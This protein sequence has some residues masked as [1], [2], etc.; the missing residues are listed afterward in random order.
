[1]MALESKGLYFRLGTVIL[2]IFYC[3]M[4]LCAY[5]LFEKCSLTCDTITSIRLRCSF[6]SML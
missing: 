2:F 5:T 4:E 6:S 1:M 3:F